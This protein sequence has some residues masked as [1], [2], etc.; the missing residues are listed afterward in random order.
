MADSAEPHV[1]EPY[2]P[3][4]DK[5]SYVHAM[6]SET[7]RRSKLLEAMHRDYKKGDLAKLKASVQHCMLDSELATNSSVLKMD[8][9]LREAGA[10][11][12]ICENIVRKVEEEKLRPSDVQVLENAVSKLEKLDLGPA[13]WKESKGPS[14]L[15]PKLPKVKDM[16]ASKENLKFLSQEFRGGSGRY[17]TAWLRAVEECQLTPKLETLTAKWF[18]AF[19]DS[20]QQ[21]RQQ[22]EEDDVRFSYDE[23]PWDEREKLIPTARDQ[24]AELGISTAEL[25]FRITRS[26]GPDGGAVVVVTGPS[27]IL[28]TIR[29]IGGTDCDRERAE[30]LDLGTEY[31]RERARER[32]ADLTL[33]KGELTM[34]MEEPV[35]RSHK[36]IPKPQLDAGDETAFKKS[37]PPV[38]EDQAGPPPPP[39]PPRRAAPSA[40]E[41]EVEVAKSA[42]PLQAGRVEV[43]K[44]APP[45]RSAAPR[46]DLQMPMETAAQR[47]ARVAKILNLAGLSDAKQA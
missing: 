38:S 29:E 43:V 6:C 45:P 37:V 19:P 39:P 12:I 9:A 5:R 28:D 7:V 40:E 4:L 14:I 22:L 3:L 34:E 15:Y 25:T 17:C 20:P 1:L 42:P 24:L 18:D 21:L 10:K 35:N 33:K 27:E 32:A 11:C 36:R 46:K 2:L 23:V 30:L 16:L 31:D 41:D 8:E 13:L 44:S 26:F 47:D